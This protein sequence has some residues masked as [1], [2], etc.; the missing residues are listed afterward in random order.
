M[1]NQVIIIYLFVSV[2][3]IFVHQ[4]TFH[5]IDFNKL[6][7]LGSLGGQLEE[8]EITV[9]E[10]EDEEEDVLVDDFDGQCCRTYPYN[11]SKIQRWRENRNRKEKE[12]KEKEQSSKHLANV[13]KPPTSNPE[14]A[15]NSNRQNDP[16]TTAAGKYSPPIILLLKV[17]L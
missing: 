15:I 17:C 3:Y 6:H 7:P 8:P 1:V 16:I 13:Q 12:K 5:A 9:I 4:D 10:S 14:K 2:L 11:H